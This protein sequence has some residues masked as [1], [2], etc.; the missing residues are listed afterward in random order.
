MIGYRRSCGCFSS[1]AQG[2][3]ERNYALGKRSRRERGAG[4]RKTEWKLSIFLPFVF[5][6]YDYSCTPL[7]TSP[8]KLVVSLAILSS[9]AGRR[10]GFWIFRNL[11]FGD[12]HNNED[13]QKTLTL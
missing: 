10:P 8:T 11:D 7:R 13:P 2:I 6:K 12:L 4:N 1:D 5:G 9:S 3:G